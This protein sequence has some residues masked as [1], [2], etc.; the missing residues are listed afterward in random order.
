MKCIRTVVARFNTC[1]IRVVNF[2]PGSQVG[3]HVAMSLLGGLAE[4][5]S[6]RN[7]PMSFEMRFDGCSKNRQECLSSRGAFSRREDFPTSALP[8]VFHHHLLL[9]PQTLSVPTVSTMSRIAIALSLALGATSVMAQGV[10]AAAGPVPLFMKHF[11]YTDLVKYFQ[12]S[13]AKIHEC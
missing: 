2:P 5:G 12:F 8:Q 3:P 1:S 7:V 11:P 13:F 10:Q 6:R 9:L 4:H